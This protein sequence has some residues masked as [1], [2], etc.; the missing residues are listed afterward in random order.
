MT[1]SDTERALAALARGQGGVFTRAQAGQV[2]VTRSAVAHRL[3]TA[4]WR[5]VQGRVLAGATTELGR[6]GRSWSALL[7]AGPQAVF[8]HGTAAGLWGLDAPD[9]GCVELTT[10]AG[11]TPQVVGAR[12]RRTVLRPDE[13]DEV[14]GFPVTSVRRTLLD[15]LATLAPGDAQALADRAWRRRLISHRELVEATADRQGIPGVAQLCSLTD[16]FAVGRAWYPSRRLGAVLRSAGI[17]GWRLDVDVDT[18]EGPRCVP[19]AFPRERLALVVGERWAGPLT[20]EEP[21]GNALQLAGWTVLH[22]PWRTALHD[23]QRVLAL[24]Q[25]GRS[26]AAGKPEVGAP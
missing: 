12:V 10:T 18:P 9:P 24:V 6:A 20:T 25:Q 7:V 1:T 8:S 22:L 13:V 14:R 11:R 26:V 4:Q 23:R 19:L 5:V 3:R 15:C 17:A 16:G 2:G 21:I